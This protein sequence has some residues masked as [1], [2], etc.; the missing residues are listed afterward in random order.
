MFEGYGYPPT[1]RPPWRF[2]R[3]QGKRSVVKTHPTFESGAGVELRFEGVEKR[4]VKNS[5][6]KMNVRVH[7][8]LPLMNGFGTLEVRVGS[9]AIH[10]E[11]AAEI[12]AGNG[13]GA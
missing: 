12:E 11:K 1:P 4:F 8:H 13:R 3:V 6:E 5:L 2:L 9:A 10:H 7:S